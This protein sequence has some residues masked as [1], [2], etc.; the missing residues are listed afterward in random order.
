MHC[1]RVDAFRHRAA[2]IIAD[3]TRVS[4]V[5]PL[6]TLTGRLRYFPRAGSD[7]QRRHFIKLLGAAA[8]GWPLSAR[9]QQPKVARIGWLTTA[10][11]AAVNPF[12]KALRAGLA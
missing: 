2:A 5:Y 4:H 12:V 11:S 8:A 10:P 3:H 9:S 6:L 1:S 7:M